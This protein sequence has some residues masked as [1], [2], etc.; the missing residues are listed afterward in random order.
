M[1]ASDL[2]ADLRE[3]SL[4]DVQERYN[5]LLETIQRLESERKE[6][7]VVKKL[8]SEVIRYAVN[9]LT[10]APTI[11][12]IAQKDLLEQAVAEKQV[13]DE[14]LSQRDALN[15][16][17]GVPRY[18]LV[19]TL[20]EFHRRLTQN[21]HYSESP[22]LASEM[23]MFSRFF[24]IQ[25]MI[26]IYNAHRS[27][28][29]DIDHARGQLLETVKAI[30]REDRKFAQQ[31]TANNSETRPLRREA[32]RLRAFLEK[33]SKQEPKPLP[34]EI[35]EFSLRLMAGDSLSME[36]FSSMLS[37]GG[38]TELEERGSPASSPQKRKKKTQRR[39]D[40]M[41]GR[42]RTSTKK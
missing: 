16:R 1:T 22:S 27:L 7:Y 23:D 28:L 39:V 12:N 13:F 41:P 18:R 15:N 11:Q 34:E 31:L 20:Q 6:M 21:T 4:D 8:R 40:P 2:F 42:K 17:M 29:T 30:N 38:L 36:E 33:K 37:H 26:E 5:T 32:G 35:E 10:T 3:L 9:K 19:D 24:E 14:L 25:T